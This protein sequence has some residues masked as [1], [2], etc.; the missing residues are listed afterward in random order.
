[1]WVVGNGNLSYARH[2]TNAAIDNY[3][4]NMKAIPLLQRVDSMGDVWIGQYMN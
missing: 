2:D 3:H 4:A 1:M